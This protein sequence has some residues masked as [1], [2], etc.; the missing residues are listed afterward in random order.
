LFVLVIGGVR[1]VS[2]TFALNQISPSLGLPMGYVYL[3]IPT[4]G[5]LFIY[6]SLVF[7]IK[8]KTI[9]P[10]AVKEHHIS[11]VD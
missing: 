3:V 4:T 7:I 11:A 10:V 5:I 6:Y 9:K 2:L 8:A 1:L